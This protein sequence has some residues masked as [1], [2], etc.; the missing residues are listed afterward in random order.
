M[1]E[2]IREGFNVEIGDQKIQLNFQA[3]DL[4]LLKYSKNALKPFSNSSRE[5]HC[6]VEVFP[7][8]G[9][10]DF[11]WKPSESEIF[12]KYFTDI[13]RRFPANDQPEKIA[14]SSLEIIKCLNPEEDRIKRIQSGIE[15]TSTLI[16]S[17]IMSDVYFFDTESLDAILFIKR[18]NKIIVNLA[19]YRHVKEP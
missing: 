15:K 7:Y 8:S 1:S 4:S 2:Q 19:N 10:H 3:E 14:D 5:N 13:A 9:H 12:R 17:R 11:T 6:V 18:S 16:Y